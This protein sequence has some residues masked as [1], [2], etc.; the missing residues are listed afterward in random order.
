MFI[1]IFC[2]LLLLLFLLVDELLEF[3][4][5]DEGVET[6]LPFLSR[7]GVVVKKNESS[8][9]FV[10]MSLTRVL[11]RCVG[12]VLGGVWVLFLSPLTLLSF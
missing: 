6:N 7:M 2:S 1:I 5:D 12:V 8:P 11:S 10:G 4:L 3:L 9:E